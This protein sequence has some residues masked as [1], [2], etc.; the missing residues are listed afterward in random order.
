MVFLFAVMLAMVLT[1]GYNCSRYANAAQSAGE[2]QG[3]QVI[4]E[5]NGVPIT[6]K[7]Y[8]N[9]YKQ[10][11]AQF[12][13][14]ISMFPATFLIQLQG[15]ALD[16]VIEQTCLMALVK[17]EGIELNEKTILAQFDTLV[18]DARPKIRQSL[19]K[20]KK[21]KENSTEAEFE[22]AFKLANKGK[23]FSDVVAEARTQIQTTLADAE[24]RPG[25]E[26]QIGPE[27]LTAKYQKTLQA[28]EDDVKKSYDLFEVKQILLG[29][30]AKPDPLIEDKGKK[31]VAEIKSGLRFEDAMD[32]YSTEK[33]PA[34][35]KKVHELVQ[36][37]S[38]NQ[39]KSSPDLAP[40]LSLKPGEVSEPAKIRQG[41]VIYKLAGIVRDLPKDYEANKALYKDGYLKR[42][43]QDMIAEKLKAFK[44]QTPPKFQAKGF[45][46]LY[47][48]SQAQRDPAIASD[49]K[50]IDTLLREVANKAKAALGDGRT[51]DSAI[52]RGVYYS[53]I[54]GL[55]EKPDLKASVLDEYIAATVAF[56]ETNESVDLR[57]SL[58]ELYKG[59]KDGVKVGE[60]MIAALR[61]NT[62]YDAGGERKFSDIAAKIELYK[63][64]NLLSADTV[65]QI[66]QEQQHWRDEKKLADAAMARQKQQEAEDKRMADEAMRIQ[67]EKDAK[68]KATA[69]K[70]GGTTPPSKFDPAPETNTPK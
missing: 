1:M 63:K 26:A 23:A 42:Q 51:A 54:S 16:G 3:T 50:K 39:L 30:P 8:E 65:K 58:A 61:A 64:D 45:E 40:V 38:P 14:N 19:I 20:D 37:L 47:Q 7:Q 25:L 35:N 9:A 15:S 43:A 2:A 36:K 59:K 28:T 49:P 62:S 17:K 67:K 70:S 12:G 29:D 31:I 34:P 46:A 53:S 41:V 4:A 32:K 18:V 21:L 10:Q 57:L 56:V 22:A 68:E 33:N 55:Y 48:F 6:F 27:M 52:A 13:S 5:I 24:K 69:P 11:T 66:E 60:Q 44:Q